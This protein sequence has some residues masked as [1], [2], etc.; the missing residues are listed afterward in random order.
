MG[1][2]EYGAAPGDSDGSDLAELLRRLESELRA[3]GAPIV[4]S[5]RTGVPH[6]DLAAALASVGLHTPDDLGTWFAWH[7]GA[8][9]GHQVTEGPGIYLLPENALA[10]GWHVLTIADAIRIRQWHLDDLANIGGA[11]LLPTSWLPVLHANERGLLCADCDADVPS[12]YILDGAAGLPERP[13]HPQF[14][15]FS[16]F[17]SLLLRLFDESIVR[18]DSEMP[19][20]AGLNFADL[21]PALRKLA[22]W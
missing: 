15:S 2:N 11:D 13:P 4:G 21:D 6:T 7:D 22:T 12:L 9:S 5:F 10:A 18:S 1:V 3:F 20:A 17:V 14:S 19:G 8:D 16:E